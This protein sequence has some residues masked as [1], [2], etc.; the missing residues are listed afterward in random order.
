MNGI[1][2]FTD[3]G[4]PT[5]QIKLKNNIFFPRDKLNGKIYLKS[6][7]FLTNGII[8]FEIF[9]QEKISLLEKNDLIIELN[10]PSKIFSYCLKYPGLV[11]YSLT[12]GINIPFKI[13]LPSN[14]LPSFEFSNKINK[15]GHIKYFL[16]IEIPELNLKQQK[17]III[18][19]ELDIIKMNSP[20]FFKAE[21]NEKIFGIFKQNI[22]I[23][24]TSLEKNYYFFNEEILLKICYN[25]NN[26]IFCL[27]YL[28]IRLL[29]NI[30]FKLKENNNKDNS[31]KKEINDLIFNDEL[32]F[33][34]IYID[35]KINNKNKDIFFDVKIK[36]EEPEKIFNN[37]KVEYLELGLKDKTQLILFLPSLDSN[38]FKCEY[39]IK[40]EGVFDSIIPMENL[41]INMP[42]FVYHKY[43]DN[44]NKENN[45]NN[46]YNLLNSNLENEEKNYIKDN[47]EDNNNKVIK[48]D[49]IYTNQDK[50]EWNNKTN[51]QIIPQLYNV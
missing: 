35:E 34:K 36:I 21:K 46:E 40:V 13:N 50:K 24:S 37:H 4:N 48:E 33:E 30:V 5:I 26:S 22:P 10:K 16:Q 44:N 42:I 20:L 41:Y 19:K 29:R 27:K 15:Y 11:N 1:N 43:N 18:R 31:N 28:N 45:E 9:Y 14:I 47:N 3:N 25:T 23:L 17:F 7:N 8:K 32:Y 51:G 2:S 6:G 49:A 39:I 12:K 38:L